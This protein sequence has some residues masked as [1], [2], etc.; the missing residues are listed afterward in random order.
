MFQNKTIGSISYIHFQ[1]AIFL[2][3]LLLTGCGNS[4]TRDAIIKEP[5][6]TGIL[7]YNNTRPIALTK[8]LTVYENDVLTTQLVAADSEDDI[9][10]FVLITETRH[11]SITLFSNG[12]LT[13]T[14]DSGYS[15]ID[16]FSY[17][18]HDATL[19]S[20][21]QGV[22]ISVI[23]PQQQTTT[24]SNYDGDPFITVWEISSNENNVTIL[25]DSDYDYDYKIVWGDGTEDSGIDGDITHTYSEDDNYTV[26]I[27]GTFPAIRYEQNIS[28]ANDSQHN[29]PNLKNISAWG[30]IEWQ[31]MEFAFADCDKLNSD[32]NDTPDLSD[33]SSLKGMFANASDFNASIDNWDTSKI[34]N[35]SYMFYGA[36]DFDQNLSSWDTTH[37]TTMAYMFYD[38]SFNKDIGDWNTSKVKD[39][40]ATFANTD[41][42]DQNISNWNT[43]NVLY[44]SKMFYNADAF[45]QNLSDWNISQVITLKS[46]FEEADS[47]NNDLSKWDT[48]SVTDMNST[49]SNASDFNSSVEDWNT[50]NVT[51]MDKMFY[52][53][54]DFSDHN[55]SDWNVSNVTSHD[56]FLTGA[57]SNNTEPDWED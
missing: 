31:S 40:N 32:A 5:E 4:T 48:S 12:E 21:V 54:S 45:D 1:Y 52:N 44:M 15:G 46:M 53:A 41:K 55:L 24:T 33:V 11:G 43:S 6:T 18:V 22:T 49:F 26:K 10:T 20:D 25:T 13:Y 2:S 38:T 42:F 29:C 9:L 39:M 37:V 3:S 56:D 34:E 14:P 36:T 30:E 50:S 23:K 47:F 35:M 7:T 16:K 28:T 57:G 27:Y 8:E 51:T 19:S 17:R